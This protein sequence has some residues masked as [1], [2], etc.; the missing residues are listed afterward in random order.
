MLGKNLFCYKRRAQ[1]RKKIVFEMGPQTKKHAGDCAMALT[2]CC[3]VLLR[4]L[5]TLLFTRTVKT[6]TPPSVPLLP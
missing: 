2:L 5:L 6:H 1:L 3:M 4:D